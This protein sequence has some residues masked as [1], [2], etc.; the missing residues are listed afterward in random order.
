MTRHLI[1]AVALAAV[2][3][4]PAAAAAQRETETVDRTVALPSNGTLELRNFSGR[5]RITASSGTDVVIKAV[6][7]AE[8]PQLDGITLDIS[9]SASTVRIDANRKSREWEDRD[10]N[11]VDTEF[12]IQVPSSARLD[13]NV[14]SSELTIT[15]VTGAQKIK[16]FSGNIT[17]TGARGA[18]DVDT[19]S[20][21][22][23]VDLAAA[24]NQPDLRVKTFNGRID[25]R[26]AGSASGQV[27]F[28]TSSGSLDS[29]V[30]LTLRTSRRRN[31]TAE[32]GGGSGNTLRFQTFS[33]DVRVKR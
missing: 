19:F 5:V 15:G 31:I 28:N 9:T 32:L 24:G 6:R 2:L 20:G 27:E 4:F 33:G 23:D 1:P 16:T 10:N 18:L 17:V 26:L 25:A 30:P 3:A 8:R 7:R 29:D 22:V 11:V 21:D 13:V 14:F 12:D